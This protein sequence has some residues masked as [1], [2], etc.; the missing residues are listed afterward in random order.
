LYTGQDCA[1][2][3][4]RRERVWTGTPERR[5]RSRR[6]SG[7]RHK[8]TDRSRRASL[9]AARTLSRSGQRRQGGMSL[10]LRSAS[11][12]PRVPAAGVCGRNGGERGKRR[13]RGGEGCGEE[14]GASPL[15]S[16]SSL[17]PLSFLFLPP[18]LL[19][20]VSCL[21]SLFLVSCPVPSSLSL[22]L[23]SCPSSLSLVSHPVPSSSSCCFRLMC[24]TNPPY[25][26]IHQWTM[27]GRV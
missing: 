5:A 9:S 14:R 2:C 21:L 10:T 16:L 6:L 23:V 8:R 3:E 13:E 24:L 11:L 18:C 25:T 26:R 20:L 22:V 27:G 17:F 12:T 7:Q 15:P 4:R 1:A 19:S